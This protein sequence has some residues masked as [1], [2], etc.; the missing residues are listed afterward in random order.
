MTDSHDRVSGARPDDDAATDRDAMTFFEDEAPS[1]VRAGGD[2]GEG[3]EGDAT[4]GVPWP[5]AGYTGGLAEG[6]QGAVGMRQVVADEAA[7]R[8][9][10][11][12]DE[13]PPSNLAQQDQ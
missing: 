9:R 11:G 6:N 1:R 5:N 3:L 4:G 13:E 10:D 8:R 2:L 7:G 12:F